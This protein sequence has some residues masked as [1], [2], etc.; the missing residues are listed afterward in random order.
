MER[1]HRPSPQDN[2]SKNK[3][4]PTL[5]V[6]YDSTLSAANVPYKVSVDTEKC[7]NLLRKLDI[8]EDKIGNLQLRI[9]RDDDKGGMTSGHFDPPTQ[10]I[11][12]F[13]DTAWE[14]KKDPSPTFV[15][16]AQ[17]A[18]D[19]FR[20]KRLFLG[21]YVLG[22]IL[23]GI[24][25]SL[26]FVG[27]GA[28]IF[29]NLQYSIYS[30]KLIVESIATGALISS[31]FALVFYFLAPYMAYFMNPF[32][33]RAMKAAEKYKNQSMAQDLVKLVPKDG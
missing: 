24:A 5:A 4:S 30:K 28:V 27:A 2:L 9:K 11:D 16:E 32:E 26:P 23:N 7:I 21:S 13:T 14:Y 6:I 1:N 33:R 25:A 10:S 19:Y 12:V 8:P 3:F 29:D 17:H 22:P 15:H 20:T 18:K 31:P